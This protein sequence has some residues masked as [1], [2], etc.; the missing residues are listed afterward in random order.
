MKLDNLGLKE[1]LTLK[2]CLEILYSK[3]QT[4]SILNGKVN[5]NDKCVKIFNLLENVINEI[6]KKVFDYD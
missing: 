2:E 1:L 3:Y 5:N 4:N 6:E